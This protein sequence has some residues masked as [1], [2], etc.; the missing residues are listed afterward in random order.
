MLRMTVQWAE[1]GN[2]RWQEWW[3]SQHGRNLPRQA[4]PEE[5]VGFANF[6]LSHNG[7]PKLI[8]ARVGTYVLPLVPDDRADLAT[9]I[10]RE[11]GFA[12]IETETI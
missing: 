12:V 3:V 2:V 8:Q 11:H 4:T 10:L 6:D 9:R 1:Y 7:L 5:H